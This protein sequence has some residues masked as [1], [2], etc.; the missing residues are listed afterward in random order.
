MENIGLNPDIIVNQ[1]LSNQ[2]THVVWLPDTETSF[3]YNKI[4]ANPCLD[5]VQVCREGEAIA[6]GIGLWVGGKNPVVMV[7]NTGF[8]EFFFESL[9]DL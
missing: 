2:V 8:F 9:R 1:L 7:Q 4:L 5:I 6:V 3:M